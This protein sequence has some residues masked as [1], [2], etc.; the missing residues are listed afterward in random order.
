MTGSA[1]DRHNHREQVAVIGSGIAGLTAAYVLQRR[2]DVMLFEADNRLG[3]HA[4]T[5]EVADVE[6]RDDADDVRTV[7]K[8]VVA[9][10]SDQ[11]LRLLADPTP[12]EAAVLGAI[13]YSVN[14]TVL[15]TDTALLPSTRAA[16]SSWNYLLPSRTRGS[17]DRAVVTYAMNQL[18][19]LTTPVEYLVTMNATDRIDPA[20]VIDRM[21]YE[22]PAYT[23]ESVAARSR[24]ATLTT[25]RTAFA[26]AYHGWG[27]HE[28]GCASGVAAAAAFGV[29]W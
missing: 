12:A 5:H 14:E 9:T 24:L 15:H 21:R 11:A 6:I 4:H 25:A 10:H 3:G 8:V 23:A 27:F 19:H 13:P 1:S 29:T 7:A 28:D 17:A 18:H 20:T 2:Y 16:Y 22:H 26:G